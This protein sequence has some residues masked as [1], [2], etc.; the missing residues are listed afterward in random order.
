MEDHYMSV[1]TKSVNLIL[2]LVL[3]MICFSSSHAASSADSV[4]LYTPYTKISVPP[5]QSIDYSI[6]IINNSSEIRNADISISGLPKGWI[7]DM[8]SG[9]WN[10]G[11][12][13]VLPGERKTINLKV[14]VPL[15]VNKG[16]YRFRVV[17]GGF[18]PLPL[19]VI[20]S[21]QGTF[22]TEFTSDQPNMEGYSNSTFTF[23]VNLKNRTAEKQ[24]YALIANTPRGW[25]LTFKSSNYQQVT[26]V[27]AEANSAQTLTIEVKPPERVEA[28]KYKIPL[29][30]STSSTSANL[31]L[32]VVI[33]GTFSIGLSTSNGLLST[34]IT[35]GKQ[36]KIDLVVNNIGSAELSDIKLESAEPAKWEV[37]LDPREVRSLP[38]GNS[39]T[40]SAYIKADKK[41]IPGDYVTNIDA[42]TPETSA[43]IT[44][45]I[46][47]ETPLFMGWIGI[48]V[49]VIALGSV[50]YLFRKFGR[51]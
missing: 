1:R 38:A 16:A 15:K 3:G 18:D 46:S 27:I 44:F 20:V 2:S 37:M 41:A 21:E 5:G 43:R 50:Y 25:N 39:V 17:A 22:K 30:A 14:D 49:I 51:R 19:T 24:L 7:C 10:I 31:D 13:S 11:Q 9:G 36:R 34:S 45:R 47:V 8:K 23:T 12:L 28:G 29:S 48:L 40:V 26:S 32:E 35:A 4:K 42:R 6:D 33:K